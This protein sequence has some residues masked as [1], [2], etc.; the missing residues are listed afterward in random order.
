[1][2]EGNK[3]GDAESRLFD[4]FNQLKKDRDTT[5][6]QDD[7]QYKIRN[8]LLREAAANI[9]STREVQLSMLASSIVEKKPLSPDEYQTLAFTFARENR[10]SIKTNPIYLICD[11]IERGI[12]GGQDY[13]IP[14]MLSDINKA[15]ATIGYDDSAVNL[16]SILGQEEKDD[17]SIFVASHDNQ[18]EESILQHR[19]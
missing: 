12:K 16:S 13:T 2:G 15:L 8:K 5:P 7:E 14:L 17:M 4:E 3:I 18:E 6:Y 11:T 1:M 9:Y 10:I 19:R